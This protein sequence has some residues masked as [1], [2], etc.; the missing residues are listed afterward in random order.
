MDFQFPNRL[1]LEQSKELESGVSY[2]EIK[3]ADYLDD[4]LK[5]FG[6]DEKW[7]G[8]IDSCLK[9]A[10]GLILVNGNPTSESKFQRG[11]K[12]EDP[13]SPFLFILIM[14]SLHLSFSKV[15]GAGLF[16]GVSINGSLMLS[17]LFYADDI[18]FIREW[19]DCNIKMIVHVLKCFF[20][21]SSLKINLHK[22]NMG[23]GVSPQDVKNAANA[24]GYTTFTTPFNY[25][26]VKVGDIMSKGNSWA[27]VISKLSS[28]LSKW[29]LKTLSSGGRLTLIKLV[30]TA[31]PLYHMSIF[32]VPICVL[33]NME[34]IRRNFFN[35]VEGSDRKLTWIAW[36]N[37][38]ASKEKGGLGVSSY[39]ALNQAILFKYLW[40]FISQYS[41]LWS[42]FIKVVHRA[43]GSLDNVTIALR[44]SHWLDI[45]WE[46][47]SLKS[48]GIDLLSYARRRI[49]NGADS[50][51]WEDLW[52]GEKTLKIQYP[53]L[54]S[55]EL[56]KDISV[57][58]KLGHPSL[59]F[60]LRRQPS[61][62]AEEEQFYTLL[63]LRTLL[64]DFLLPKFDVPTRWINV[65]PIKVNIFSWR[66]HLDK[67]PMRLNLSFKGMEIPSILC[68]SCNLSMESSSHLLFSCSLARQVWC[69]VLRWWELVD[70]GCTSYC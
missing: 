67:L 11:L 53:R 56:H 9:S 23:I 16:K 10:I 69:Q 58:E 42:K 37:V 52:I 14:E 29:K 7:R 38:L 68:P 25:L 24:V 50:M 34:S 55:L 18:V 70:N 15:L 13:L 22:S 33:N 35:G 31:I 62:G 32:K 39:F 2:D 54:Y 30:L 3:K 66:V 48:K 12:Q 49:G 28:R 27:E 41:S 61:G 45:L 64:D 44:R 8:W 60:S 6:F 57:A 19:S 51:F 21:A 65:V 1:S 47:S 5:S 63:S 59:V 46:V 43:K 4:N 26:G 20:L 40:R 36:K 17:H